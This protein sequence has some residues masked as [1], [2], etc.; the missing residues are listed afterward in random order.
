MLFPSI[1]RQRWWQVEDCPCPRHHSP[2]QSLRGLFKSCLLLPR[3]CLILTPESLEVGPLGQNFLAGYWVHLRAGPGT[4][5][6]LGQSLPANYKHSIYFPLDAMK[7]TNIFS[8][9]LTMKKVENLFRMPL[10]RRVI[11]PAQEIWASVL[12]SSKL[13]GSPT[14]SKIHLV[15]FS[16]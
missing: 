4:R 11:K 2:A 10:A 8:V 16:C 12:R 3:K 13:L 15:A 5:G 6:P 14:S 1:S 7:N 9:Y